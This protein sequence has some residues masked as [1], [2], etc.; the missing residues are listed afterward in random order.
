MDGS[1]LTRLHG[2]GSWIKAV[3]SW[4]LGGASDLPLPETVWQSIVTN[5]AQRVIETRTAP[6]GEV[7]VVALPFRFQF[8][9]ERGAR[10]LQRET[11][12]Q[13][14]IQIAEVALYV[15]GAAGVFWPLRRALAISLAA[16]IALL[17]SMTVF[18]LQFRHYLQAKQA[19]EQLA[20][21]RRVQQDLLPLECSGCGAIEFAVEFLPFSE[22]GGDY[23]D[24]FRVSDGEVALVV[25]DVAGKAC[26]PRS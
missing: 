19:E 1:A 11:T 9:D 6:R 4:R 16:A 14:R 18:T 24:V 7:L 8:L 12:G 20:I 10:A 21:A 2:S 3:G 25:G 22:V 23:Y 26:R 5:R 13:P 17:A 15:E